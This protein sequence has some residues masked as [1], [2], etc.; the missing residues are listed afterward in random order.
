[1][2]MLHYYKKPCGPCNYGSLITALTMLKCVTLK[3]PFKKT[4]T[5]L[6]FT[7]MLATF[8]RSELLTV[9]R[10]ELQQIREN[11]S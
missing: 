1:M 7:Y 9:I 8:A 4:L 11:F 3:N 5:L 10:H 6:A 2:T